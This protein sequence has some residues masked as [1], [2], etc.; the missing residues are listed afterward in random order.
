MLGAIQKTDTTTLLWRKI[1]V[2][3]D[4]DI[5]HRDIT[6]CCIS[7]PT[8]TSSS[9]QTIGYKRPSTHDNRHRPSYYSSSLQTMFITFQD[10][11]EALSWIGQT[12]ESIAEIEQ[13]SSISTGRDHNT[14]FKEAEELLGLLSMKI[15][16]YSSR[17]YTW[18]K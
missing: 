13:Q 12:T 1:L 14:E 11:D 9:N 2:G 3:V 15:A 10:P 6:I 18:I 7:D 5:Q 17:S 8:T 4:D 16:K